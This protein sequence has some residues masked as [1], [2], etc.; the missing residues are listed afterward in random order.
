MSETKVFRIYGASDDLVETE[1][2]PG[3]DEFEA[4][5]TD[6][7]VNASFILSGPDGSMR[8][9]AMYAPANRCGCW[10]FAPMQVEEGEPFPSWPLRIRHV[11][12]RGEPGYSTV[13]EIEV[14][15]GTRL[16]REAM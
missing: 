4:W 16:I 5:G 1:G 9:V 3:C 2:V 6:G 8:I 13:L 12:R 14:P 15:D 10:A 11:E 7:G